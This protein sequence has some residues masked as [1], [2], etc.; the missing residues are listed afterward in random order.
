MSRGTIITEIE[1]DFQNNLQLPDVTICTG[2]YYFKVLS[3]PFTYYRQQKKVKIFLEKMN[4]DVYNTEQ[5]S[6]LSKLSLWSFNVDKNQTLYD[7]ELLLLCKFGVIDCDIMQFETAGRVSMSSCVLI[8]L[9]KQFQKLSVSNQ[10]T[11]RT[12]TIAITP[13]RWL[14]SFGIKAYLSLYIHPPGTYPD[15]S[16]LHKV[17]VDKFDI[18]NL[19]SFHQTYY[20]RPSFRCQKHNEDIYV[21]LA[22]GTLRKYKYTQS[23]CRA[24]HFQEQVIKECGCM[25]EL[26]PSAVFSQTHNPDIKGCH[27]LSPKG[28]SML[29]NATKSYRCHQKVFQNFSNAHQDACPLP[30]ALTDYAVHD[31]LG[32]IPKKLNISESEALLQSLSDKSKK[33][34][35]K[36]VPNYWDSL[37]KEKKMSLI[38]ATIQLDGPIFK[39]KESP[40]DTTEVM[41]GMC[42]S[43]LGL[44]FGA[45]VISAIEFL[46]FCTLAGVNRWQNRRQ[47]KILSETS[48]DKF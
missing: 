33:K 42:G 5:I 12:L 32:D 24:Q 19:K 48:L 31:A 3:L 34:Y 18:L 14:F 28:S 2:N 16:K 38:K 30:C 4:D 35:P 20:N 8:S 37:L 29:E 25:S 7:T 47:M 46:E 9:Q 17:P 45:S 27:D 6:L 36:L 21:R 22:H 44:Y 15:F 41:L 26:L 23:L 11:S 13:P 43:V 10:E 1:R 39:I 40:M